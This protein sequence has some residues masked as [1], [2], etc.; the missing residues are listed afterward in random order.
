MRHARP[1]TQIWMRDAERDATCYTKSARGLKVWRS[2]VLH[3]D[4]RVLRFQL[5]LLSQTHSMVLRTVGISDV[6]YAVFLLRS[7]RSALAEGVSPWCPPLG[8]NAE[9]FWLPLRDGE[10]PWPSSR[11]ALGRR[12]RSAPPQRHHHS[13]SRRATLATAHQRVCELARR[14]RSSFRE[15]LLC[16]PPTGAVDLR[17]D[18]N[19]RST[20]PTE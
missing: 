7:V 20:K 5:G 6:V 12:E 16:R 8:R 14:R 4:R 11:L 17:S 19:A 9:A 10:P 13:G 1:E 2:R 18:A 3:H 15:S